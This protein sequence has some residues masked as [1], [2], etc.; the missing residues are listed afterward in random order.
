MGHVK[1]EK[2]WHINY[3]ILYAGCYIAFKN[4]TG[5]GIVYEE[6]VTSLPGNSFR[7]SFRDIRN[8]ISCVT[9][10]FLE[11]VS[12]IGLYGLSLKFIPNDN[13]SA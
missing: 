2:I 10:R 5:W 12:G 3:M 13:A 9:A 7:K 11:I 4:L 6:I 1:G 8:H